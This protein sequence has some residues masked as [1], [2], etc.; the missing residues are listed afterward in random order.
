MESLIIHK[1]PD[2]KNSSIVLGFSGWMNGGNVSTDTVEYLRNK[3]KAKKFA[4]INPKDF[5]I[6]NL[7]G[8]MQEVAYFRPYAKIQDGLLTDFQYPQNDFFYDEKNNLI[9]FSGKEPNLR[10]DDYAS[11]VFE[12]GKEFKVKRIYFIGS[13][14]GPIPHTRETRI[15]CSFSSEKQKVELKNYDVRFTNYEGPASITTLLTKLSKKKGIEM[16]NFVTEIPIY[17]QT[18]NPKGIKAIV[19]RLVKLLDIDI[20]LGDLSVM[21]NEFEKNINELVAKQ[22]QLA[23]QIKKLEEN[24]DKELFDQRENFEEWLKQHGIDKL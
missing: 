21:S 14:A 2:L 24:Y 12:L 7:P 10:W 23:E 6:F 9:L 19:K 4:E 20:D 17:V 8:T 13:V 11:C 3:L 18:K 1:K 15:S 5:Y 16:I 22:P